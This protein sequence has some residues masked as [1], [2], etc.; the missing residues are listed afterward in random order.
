MTGGLR[1]AL[2]TFTV[3]PIRGADVTPR[4][5]ATAMALGPVV[6]AGLGAV[7][8][9]IVLAVRGAGGPVMIGAIL[10]VAALVLLTR[11][12]HLDGL[13]DTVDGLGSYGDAERTLAVMKAP[14]VG[15]FGVAAIVLTLLTQVAAITA[16]GARPL[17]TVVAALATAVATGRLAITWACRNGVPPARPDGLGA[18]V[19]GS[20]RTPV[21]TA[22]TIAVAALGVLAAPHRPWLGP[23]AV[24]GALLIAYGFQVHVIR[25]IG[26]IT[27]DVLGALSELATCV[28]LVVLTISA[29]S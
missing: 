29:R 2:T 12:L 16:L 13:A 1:L 27:G 26:G 10:A 18:A 3:L 22:L 11:G 7:A 25:R 6:G 28:S 15:P 21:A 4:T 19:A 23:L 20:V 24:M 9:G 8:A 5:A 17:W 14:D